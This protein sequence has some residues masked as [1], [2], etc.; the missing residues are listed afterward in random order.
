MTPDRNC[1]SALARPREDDDLWSDQQLL[2][3]NLPFAAWLKDKEGRFLAANKALA[4]SL[5]AARPD[6][7]I[8]K[9]DLDLFPREVAERN[10]AE[11]RAV[12]ASGEMSQ[13]EEA[14]LDQEQS[15]WI[16]TYKA[17]AVDPLGRPLGAVGFMRDISDRKAAE[18]QIRS[19]AYFDSLTGLPNR[20]L[21]LD[22]LGQAL[23]ASNRSRRYGALLMLDLD[24]FKTLN[25]TRGHDAGDRL[26]AEVA[27]RLIAVLRECDTVARLGGDEYMV[28]LED[29]SEQQATAANDAELVAEKI[30][31][32]LSAPYAIRRGE[33]GYRC[34]S[35]IG[36]TLFRGHADAMDTLLKQA[37]VALY[38][39][40]NAGRNAVRFFNPAMQT[41]IASRNA[42]ESALRRALRQDELQLHFQPQIDQHGRCIGVE[43]LLRWNRPGHGPLYPMQ[44][45]PLAEETGLILHLGQ[46]VVSRACDQLKAWETSE[47]T[48]SLQLSINV[49]ARQLHQSEL[50]AQVDECLTR[51]GVNPARLKLELTESAFLA[52]ADQ[53]DAHMQ[54]LRALGVGFSLDDFGTGYSSLSYLKRLPFDQLKIDKTFVRD[55]TTDPN[56]AAIVSAILAVSRSLDLEIVA[57][58]VETEAQRDFLLQNGCRTFQGY[59]FGRPTPIEDL[60]RVL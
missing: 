30:R 26:L 2:L 58:G 37:D 48:R 53:V 50:V 19:L 24:D 49:S 54:Q 33:A 29:L 36:V 55:I 59:L 35:S 3:D 43:A 11:D 51:S 39:A 44:F 4:D 6:L 40:K 22:R 15:R 41:A 8:G 10:R 17:T 21:L 56:D 34:T 25:D 45:I 13:H 46:W 18:E 20:R 23:I 12:L 7:L 32:A 9:T 47:R 1:S 38:Q 5:G 42:L 57:E 28:L 16:E 31:A 27:E 52:N 14:V 60:D